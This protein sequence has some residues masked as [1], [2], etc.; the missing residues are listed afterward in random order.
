M[1][2]DR[3]KK[4]PNEEENSDNNDNCS[5]ENSSDDTNNGGISFDPNNPDFKDIENQL[6]QMFRG[7]MG[8]M[9]NTN[10]DD[11]NFPFAKIMEEMMKNLGPQL[12][13]MM[14]DNDGKPPSMEEL[15]ELVR[16]TMESQGFRGSNVKSPFSFGI[17]MTMGKDGKMRFNP[18]NNMNPS[19]NDSTTGMRPN[20]RRT[21]PIIDVI[22]EK[23]QITIIAEMP[24]VTREEIRF[25]FED[26]TLILYAK[27]DETE[28]N[29]YGR[30]EMPTNVKTNEIKARFT[31]GILELKI[32]KK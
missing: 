17:N 28:K 16:K 4:K 18:I 6:N 30:T 9:G 10:A 23:D 1:W 15:N 22:D 25:E 27:N 14:A 21:N 3:R 7:L 29:Y 13:K 19:E 32:K 24:G 2:R 31:N 12:N 8:S 11:F 20:D 26:N 5:E